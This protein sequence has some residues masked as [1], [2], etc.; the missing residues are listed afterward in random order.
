MN[1][2]LKIGVLALQGAYQAHADAVRGQG[3]EVRLVRRPDR[4]Q[5]LDGL[6]VP[7][8][9][10]TTFLKH[11]EQDGF[12]DVLDQFVREKPTFGTCAGAILLAT[13]VSNP[14]QRSLAAMDISIERNAYGRQLESTIL[15]I[16]TKL[17]GEPL[18][19]VFIRAPRISHAGPEVEIFASRDGAPVLVRQRH[20]LAATF[21]PELSSDHRVH[22]FF[23]EMVAAYVDGATPD[24]QGASA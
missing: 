4:L 3:A 6:I 10:S 13:E 21:H 20:L 12:F 9:E 23:L 5:G 8:G 18:E 1:E 16:E 15:T 2:P 14:A 24:T 11:L 7:G 22:K 17:P 19:M